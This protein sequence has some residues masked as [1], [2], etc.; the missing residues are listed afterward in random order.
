M[1]IEFNLPLS[2]RGLGILFEFNAYSILQLFFFFL[3]FLID[4]LCRFHQDR[5]EVHDGHRQLPQ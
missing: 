4:K 2:Y 3:V 1:E 5:C